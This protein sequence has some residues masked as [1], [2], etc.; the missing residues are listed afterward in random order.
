MVSWVGMITS[1]VMSIHAVR[2]AGAS[3]R[4][5]LATES[6]F[7]V[8]GRLLVLQ[9][10]AWKGQQG[11]P[12]DVMVHPPDWN[13]V[14][15]DYPEG[16]PVMLC[17]LNKGAEAR[18]VEVIT[19]KDFPTRLGFVTEAKGRVVANGDEIEF[20]YPYVPARRGKREKVTI[21]SHTVGGDGIK[22]R[23]YF[24]HGYLSAERR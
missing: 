18:E 5:R 6:P 11:Q 3:R 23:F 1:L 7:F 22:Q 2:Q 15:N 24:R 10:A 8:F 14:P 9:A 13:H 16:A 19:S 20:S 4:H 17:G 21:R 12:V